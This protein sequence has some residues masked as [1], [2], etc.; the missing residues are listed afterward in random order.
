MVQN[1]LFKVGGLS[2]YI[3]TYTISIVSV[4]RDYVLN[5]FLQLSMYTVP[6]AN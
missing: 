5:L 1:H 2:S 3:Q 6:K 4:K